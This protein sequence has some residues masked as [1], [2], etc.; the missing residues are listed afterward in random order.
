M[1]L[2]RLL[3]KCLNTENFHI[4]PKVI[5][6]MHIYSHQ[7]LKFQIQIVLQKNLYR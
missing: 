7:S 5:K 3:P 1:I 4:S 6:G 2:S